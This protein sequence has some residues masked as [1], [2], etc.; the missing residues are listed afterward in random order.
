MHSSPF[1]GKLALIVNYSPI[2]Q[3]KMTDKMVQAT[4]FDGAFSQVE[5]P[6][7]P[8]QWAYRAAKLQEELRVGQW[9]YERLI[10]E[11]G[12]YAA[13][14]EKYKG[15]TKFNHRLNEYEAI[16]ARS[17]MRFL[18]SWKSR[19]DNLEYQI[20]ECMREINKAL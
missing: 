18:K 4:L 20:E 13:T 2:R 8:N 6:R 9:D 19:K 3:V 10:P 5:A 17:I 1:G 11:Q 16:E 12:R 15:V 14:V 7:T